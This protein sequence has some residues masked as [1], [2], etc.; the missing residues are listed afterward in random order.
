MTTRGQS[1]SGITAA[2][3]FALDEAS[4]VKLELIGG[5]IVAMAGGTVNHAL[6]IGNVAG[7]LWGALGTGPCA[8][9]SSDVRVA[10]TEAGDY[11]Y[12]DGRSRVSPS[13]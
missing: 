11:V 7:A 6:I 12:P 3:Y 2:E 9:I 8:D 5:E 10:V 1:P 4:D 13:T